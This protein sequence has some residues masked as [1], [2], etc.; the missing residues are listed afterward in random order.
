MAGHYALGAQRVGG[1]GRAARQ[2]LVDVDEDL[3]GPGDLRD[4][5]HEQGGVKLDEP[6]VDVAIAIA[7]TS[8]LL[9][10]PAVSNLVAFGEVGLAGEIRAVNM[11]RARVAEGVK[12]G[13]TKCIL[14]KGSAGDVEETTWRGIVGAG[15]AA[16]EC[17]GLVFGFHQLRDRSPARLRSHLEQA[18]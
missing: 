6:A 9:N 5:G 17:F 16:E 13:F 18:E 7:L 10:A 4:L 14:P 12:F 11:S 15:R 1:D 8:S 2:V 3:P